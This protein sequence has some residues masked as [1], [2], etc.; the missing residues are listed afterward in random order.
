MQL[1][2]EQKYDERK[3]PGLIVWFVLPL[4]LVLAVA[5]S[6]F[7]AGTSTVGR[8]GE[9]PIEDLKVTNISSRPGYA[10]ADC[11]QAATEVT[12]KNYLGK[13]LMSNN[14]IVVWCAKDGGIIYRE[15][16]TEPGFVAEG[17]KSGESPFREQAKTV[18]VDS[19]EE[20]T[21]I[22]VRMVEFSNSWSSYGFSRC[23]KFTL[24][25]DG[26]A[27]GVLSCVSS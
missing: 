24:K 1:N 2:I 11:W 7:L 6:F 4:S 19:A 20:I 10:D 27:E 8:Q 25:A 17:M 22:L 18:T 12:E 21:Y 14:F 26:A 5:T 15:D 16:A 23:V 9:T 13:S 3:R